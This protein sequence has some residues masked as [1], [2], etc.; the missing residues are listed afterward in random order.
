VPLLEVLDLSALPLPSARG[1]AVDPLGDSVDEVTAVGVKT[2]RDGVRRAPRRSIA[3]INA[4]RLF[5]VSGSDV[6]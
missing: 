1:P 6:Q 2:T 3:L 4:I 5:V